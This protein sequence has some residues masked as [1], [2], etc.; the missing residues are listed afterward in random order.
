MTNQKKHSLKGFVSLLLSVIMVLSTC[1]FTV[2][3]ADTVTQGLWTVTNDTSSGTATYGDIGFT[4]YSPTTILTYGSNGGKD[5]VRS[6]NTNGSASNGIVVTSNKSYCDFTPNADGTLTVY[7]G[8]A[9]SK[10]GYVSRTDANGKSEAVGTFV[11]GGSDSYDSTGFKVT[12]GTTWATLDIEVEAGY[13]YYITLSGSKM[14]CY[15]AEYVPYTPLSG[16]INDSFNLGSYDIKF[17]NKETGES[18][19]AVVSGNSYSILL[20]PGY[21]YSAALTGSNAVGYS[22]TNDTRLI[23][24]EQAE[25]QTA[26]LTIEESVSY[27]ISGF[28]TGI[29]GVLPEDT[30]LVFVPEDTTSYENVTADIDMANMKYSAQLVANENYTLTIVGAYDYKL[31]NE[32]KVNNVDS[33]AVTKDLA[34]TA[35]PTYGVSGKFLGLTQ[36]RGQYETL[37]INPTAISFKNVE[38]GYTYS[39]TVSNGTYSVSLRNGSYVASIV[40]DNY[41]TSTHVAVNDGAVTRDLLLKDISSKNI[42][43]TDTIY[44]GSDKE[45]KSV[46]SAVDAVTN[47]TRS[48]G[49]RVTIKIDPGTYRE[50][51]V[52]NTP[53]ITLESNGGTRDNT[54]ITWYYGIGYKYYSCVNSYYDPYAD[55]DKFEK[56]NVVKY[57]GSAVITNATATGFKANNICFENSFNKYMTD[58][59]MADGAEPN[60]L[61]AIKVAR[62][63][64][65]NVDSRTATERA[66]ALVNYA[67]K[68]EFA[69]CSF[70]GS[71]DTL[72]TSNKSAF[73]SYYKNCYIEGQTDFIYG[74]GDVIFDGCEINFCGYDGTKAAGYLTANSCSSGD[75]AKAGYIFRSCYISYNGERDT[76]PGYW[77]RMWGDSAKVAFINTQLQESDMIEGVGW[78]AMTV[79]PS[80]STVTLR[81]YN[82]TYDGEKVD[83]SSRVNGAVD[84]IN[85]YDYSVENVFINNGWTPSYYTGDASTV[86]EFAS[87]PT[88]TS[89]GDLNAPNPGETITLGYALGEDWSNEDASRISWYAVTEG[90][91]DTSL[92]TILEN[93]ALLKTTSAVSTNKFQIPMECAGKYIMAVVTPI[94]NSGLT[95]TPKYIIDKEKPVS[96]TWSDPDNEGSIAPGSGIN[97][98]LAGDSTVKDYSAAGIYNGGKTLDQ[99]SW[100]EFLQ[101]FFDERYVTINN[102]AQGGRSSRSFINEG[103]LDTIASNIKAGDY[104][105]I[106]FGHN[107]CANGAS[108]YEER[109]APLYTKDNPAGDTYPTIVPTEDMKVATPT[110]LQGSY[111]STYY[112]WDCGATYKGYLQQYINIALEKGA[113]PVIVSPV[114]RLYYN[115]DGTIKAHHDANMTDYEPTMDYLTSNDAYVTACEELYNENKDKGVLYIDAFNLTKSLYEEAYKAGGSSANGDAVMAKG[116]KTHSNKTGG[117]IQAGIFAKWIQNAGISVS[118]YVIQPENVYG[119]NAD[120]NYIFTIKNSRFTAKDNSYIENSYWSVYGQELFDS[121]SG[122]VLKT[123]LNFATDDA[124]TLYETNASE[125]Y[126]DGVYSGTYTNES[127]QKFKTAV[128]QSG[129]Q[130]Y[131]GQSKYGTKATPGKAVFSFDT[132]GTGIYTINVEASTGDGTVNLYNDAACTNAV[133]AAT[134]P[135]SIVYTKTTEGVETLYFAASAANNMYISNITIEKAELPVVKPNEIMLNFA[136]DDALA[137]YETNAADTFTDGVYSGVYTNADGR[138]FE[139]SVYQSGIQYYNS[140]IRYGTKA[141]PNKPIFSFTASEAATYTID[142]TTSTGSGTIGL[143]SDAVCTN[144]VAAAVSTESLVYKKTGSDPEVLYFATPDAGNMYI[145]EITISSFVPKNILLNFATDEAL[146]MYETDA[147]TTYTG[148]VCTGTYTNAQGQSF[149]VSVYQSGIQY[150]ASQAQYGTKAS[151]GKPVFSFTADE[152]AMY[153]ITVTAGTGNG[154]L[155]LYT[156]AECTNSVV[157]GTVPG[158]VVYKKTSSTPEVL[159]AATSAANNFY[160]AEAAIKKEELPNDVKVHFTGEI[161]GV[162]NDDTN[163]IITL[164][165]ETETLTVGVDEYRTT[166]IDLIVGE[167][168]IITA[169][170]DKGVY[171][172]TDIVTD[173]SG[174][175]NLILSRL[176]FEFPLDFMEYYDDYKAYL[177]AM[178]YGNSDLTDPYSGITVHPAG[179]V[180]TD[181]YKQYGVKTNS[182]NIISFNAEQTGSCT[183]TF[184]TA[185][186]N[187]DKLI[188]K[189]NDNYAPNL[190]TAV[191]GEEIQL[192]VMVNKG[193]K[194]TVYTPTRSNLWY[195]SIDVAYADA[196][197]IEAD[198]VLNS[199]QSEIMIYGAVPSDFVGNIES[200]GFYY[201]TG[202]VGDLAGCV[203]ADETTTVYES[204]EYDGNKY[205]VDGNYIYGTVLN[206]IEEADKVYVYTF[207]KI[208]DGGT[209]YSAPVEVT[210][211]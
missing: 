205:S 25:S 42:E 1:S 197:F 17:T 156:D 24:V 50:Q 88:M 151:V 43:Y 79:D 105:L 120:G 186:S 45:Y 106:Q 171:T 27:K 174:I 158:T 3:A 26:D 198:A 203:V 189:V 41:S 62:K 104:L 149:D 127:G 173:E 116:D 11:P 34:F 44:V 69:N 84:S 190:T 209:Y 49:E 183:V 102:Y 196:S 5:Y 28:L 99:G 135:G 2:F 148:G 21:Q 74:T 179:I 201:T 131:G 123:T 13:T 109:F 37:N 18:K 126:T 137:L 77:G 164:K 95:G 10:Q 71:Q 59:E 110:A 119:E 117:V 73:Y 144:A 185:V 128:Y 211:K 81:E 168:Y 202:V 147:S 132:T 47:M 192:T 163:V 46:Q 152:R 142:I 139:A 36:V 160:L 180:M 125:T 33:T 86:P 87:D 97:I 167:T 93:A 178:G 165:G 134:A 39:G 67:D 90:Y 138:E 57:W 16:T 66:A 52:I 141:S 182:N 31:A 181:A 153:T 124:L 199:D 98:Y 161:T 14:F 191:Q 145:K 113:I 122:V 72:Y 58:E 146:K 91:D 40:S 63:E 118:P 175:A 114:A 143:Y 133:A 76:T 9:G 22:F 155:S 64:T 101:N 207:C 184:N 83:T 206:D 65:T 80:A 38:D 166:G 176:I 115:S 23:N 208:T 169:R 89:N 7:V 75:M 162:E 82:T 210:L 70:I 20:K 200:V 159:Y 8:N 187:A 32:I 85:A 56:G 111:G 29:T 55:Y 15:G 170:G 103:K 154:T 107:D 100:G 129:I 194:V 94:T 130:Y 195:K 140:D 188:L 92:D 157:S 177:E 61:E 54:K 121:L 96:N 112:S 150:Y 19:S 53:N 12:Q 78:Y 193:D 68:V 172:G 204:A 48:N 136:T 6:N 35:V 51:V 30:K 108:Y 4:Y 60:G